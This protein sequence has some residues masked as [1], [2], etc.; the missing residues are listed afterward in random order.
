MIARIGNKWS[1]GI[2][3]MVAS[4]F[5]VNLKCS[6]LKHG[7]AFSSALSTSP[8]DYLGASITGIISLI[9]P[10]A[11]RYRETVPV[12]LKIKRFEPSHVFD[13]NGI[14]NNKVG[15]PL[16]SPKSLVDGQPQSNR[17]S[18][19]V[20]SLMFGEGSSLNFGK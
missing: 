16:A 15:H 2:L 14:Y 8:H 1:I 5:V 20:P 12:R 11:G 6:S 3:I 7:S 18:R 13:R 17:P 9:I 4:L 19:K 10:E